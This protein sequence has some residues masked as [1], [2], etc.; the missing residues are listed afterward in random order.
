MN[1][2]IIS[3]ILKEICLIQTQFLVE[4]IRSKVRMDNPGISEDILEKEIDLDAISL[5]VEEQMKKRANHEGV[6]L[7]GLF[8]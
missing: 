2:K 1:D 7:D 5:K 3:V 8:D 4:K 6:S